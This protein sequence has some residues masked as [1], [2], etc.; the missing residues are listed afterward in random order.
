[1]KPKNHLMLLKIVIFG[2]LVLSQINIGMAQD[3][4]VYI[5]PDQCYLGSEVR[6]YGFVKPKP[7]GTT[8]ARLEFLTPQSGKTITRRVQANTNGEYD[9][10]FNETDEVGEWEVTVWKDG[11]SQNDKDTFTVSA[12]VFMVPLVKDL[13]AV[14]QISLDS[15]RYLKNQLANYPAFPGKDTMITEAEELI[16]KLETLARLYTTLDTAVKQMEDALQANAAAIPPAAQAA[17]RKVA[18]KAVQTST[19]IKAE[20]VHLESLFEKSKQETQWCHEWK[21]SADLFNRLNFITNFVGTA[22]EEI[23]LNLLVAKG[24]Q[25]LD[26]VTAQTIGTVCNI[27][28]AAVMGA[29]VIGILNFAVATFTSLSK[30]MFE[31]LMAKF[32]TLYKG[33]IEGDYK[34]ELLHKGA[35]FFTMTYKLTGKMELIFQ[36]RKPH[37]PAVYLK[38]ELNGKAKDIGCSITMVPFA[39]PASFTLAFCRSALPPVSRKTVLI[40]LEGKAKADKMEIKVE[41]P[42]YD[43]KL[44]AK[45]YYVIIGEHAPLPIP[46]TLEFPLMNGEWFFTRVTELSNPQKE[47]F[48]LPIEVKGNKSV[49]EEEFTREIF[50]PATPKRKAVRVTMKLEIKLSS[51]G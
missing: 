41:K 9:F 19:Q 22:L 43:Y 21:V 31:E 13:D 11:T 25:G 1:M 10:L 6:I 16:N 45:G 18:A 23:A 36:K 27:I 26:F 35:P 30:A 38:G 44:K 24:T 17:L 14:D 15:S 34:L 32:C 2:L 28:G 20:M 47:Y 7:R 46:G 33:E 49:A 40:Y 29:S 37:D 4:E 42:G 3:V 8:Y 39:L 48:E 51:K 5:E 50:L 12:V